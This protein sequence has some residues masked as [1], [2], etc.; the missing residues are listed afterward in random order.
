MLHP[1]AENE[2]LTVLPRSYPLVAGREEDPAVSFWIARVQRY[3]V[4]LQALRAKKLDELGGFLFILSQP[5]RFFFG[6][7]GILLDLALGFEDQCI[8]VA[9]QFSGQFRGIH[10]ALKNVVMTNKVD[11]HVRRKLESV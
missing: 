11:P 6:D 3:R 8:H 2:I 7:L 9:L 1:D 10:E 5:R 4:G